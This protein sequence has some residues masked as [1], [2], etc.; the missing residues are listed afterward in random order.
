MMLAL[1]ACGSLWCPPPSACVLCELGPRSRV[2]IVVGDEVSGVYLN[3]Y[4]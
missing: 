3:L 2:F 1:D 4:R